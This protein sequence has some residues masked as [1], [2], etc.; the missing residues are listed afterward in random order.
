MTERRLRQANLMGPAGLV[1]IDDGEVIRLRS[2]A[3]KRRR[4]RRRRA[5]LGRG[6]EDTDHMA[7]RPPSRLLR[8]L[9]AR[10]GSLNGG[11]D[12]PGAGRALYDDYVH[13]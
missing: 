4:R 6:V 3:S 8:A 13:F 9:P 12:R 2:A 1:S 7:T 5:P 10:H 11:A